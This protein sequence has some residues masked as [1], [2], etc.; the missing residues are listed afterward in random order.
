MR[1]ILLEGL[2]VAAIGA[3]LAFAANALSPRGIKLGRNYFPAGPPPPPTATGTNALSVSTTNLGPGSDAIIAR[4]QGKGLQVVDSQRVAEL[5]RDPRVFQDQVIFVDV[6]DD[7]HFLAGHIPGAYQFDYYHPE[8][9]LPT[10]LPAL[11]ATQLAVIYCNGGDCEDSELAAP[12]LR[13]LA[14]IPNDRVFIYPGG[15]TE[16]MKNKMPVETGARQA[17]VKGGTP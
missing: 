5:F 3:V 13:D 16:W 8:A 1:K 17:R 11:Q 4:L 12:M 15:F 2:L 9:Y 10:V 6:R 14:G 7:V